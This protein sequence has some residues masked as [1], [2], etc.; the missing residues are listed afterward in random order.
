MGI[1]RYRATVEYDGTDFHGFQRQAQGERTVQATLEDAILAV[2]QQPARII[3]AGR[4]DAGV[5]AR[6]QVI[7]FDLEW[8]H[9]QEA[10][11][12]AINANLPSDIVVRNVVAVEQGFHPRFDARQRTYQYFINNQS[13]RSPLLRRVAWHRPRPLD[14]AAMNDASS[15]L[16]GEHDLAA[17]GTPPV[18]SNT[19]RHVYRAQWRRQEGLAIFTIEANAFLYRMVRSL[20]GS[21]CLVGEGQWSVDEFARVLAAADR[22]L[23]GPTAPPLGL[24]LWSVSYAEQAGPALIRASQC[25]SDGLGRLRRC[26]D[27]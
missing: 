5:H 4:T 2:S 27:K 24:I 1:R 23:A 22:S 3:G 25:P 26:R 15:L 16:V 7:S 9:G 19:M 18:G 8:R 12:R 6:G 13:V 11:G 10:L 20:V 21:L 14:L 17:F